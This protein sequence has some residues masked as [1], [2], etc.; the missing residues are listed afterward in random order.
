MGLEQDC[1]QAGPGGAAARRAVALLVALAFLNFCLTFHNVWPT[2]WIT[3]RHELS[4]ELAALVLLLAIV[5]ERRGRSPLR[6]LPWLVALLAA[7]AVGRYAEVTAPALH[8]RPVNLYWDAR[9]LHRLA[10]MLVDASPPWL[11]AALAG[12]LA[13][14][15]AGLVAA[16]RWALLRVLGALEA[17]APRRTLGAAAAALLVLYAAGHWSP[18]VGGLHLFSAPVAATYWQQARFLGEA[19]GGAPALPERRD[20]PLA[21]RGLAG[22]AGA[23]VF[24]VFVESYGVAAFDTPT[25]ARALAPARERLAGAIAGSG[26]SIASARVE[27]PTFGG[28][29]W[30][31]H[32]SF[33]TGVEV[34]D[35]AAHRLMLAADRDTLPRVFARAGFRSVALMPG[36][37]RAWPEG[38]FFGFERIYGERALAY[39]GPPFG[40]WRIPDQF[41]LAR[42]DALEVAGGERRPLFV[43]FP[44]ITTHV[45]FR[46][47]PP[48]QPDWPRML[49]SSPFD[50]PALEASLAGAPEWM[51]LGP[52]YVD[53]LDYAYRCLA[54]YLEWRRDSDLV[55]IVLGDH[56]PAASVSGKGASWEVPVH[57]IAGRPQ[58]L[59]ALVAAGFRRGLEPPAERLGAMHEL[60]DVVTDAF[61]G[62]VRGR[63][64]PMREERRGERQVDHPRSRAGG[65]SLSR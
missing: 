30:L 55:L 23:D 61:A 64:R 49:S 32:T 54:G 52:A 53:A 39:G 28:A 58:V 7:L 11:L 62:G 19:L 41:A 56:Q 45:P 17:T 18:A 26:R 43:F 31:A 57:V 59:D 36:L 42:L 5:A 14:A 9:H 4:A 12:G 33:L 50:G 60:T 34:R 10:G 8:G 6:A 15:G 22:V 27:S 1:R 21:A 3:T 48:Y 29:S 47:T 63:L 37:R 13:V 46:P 51:N 20:R 44:T 65:L 40:W 25:Y 38:A 2:L 24:V 16:L 35:G